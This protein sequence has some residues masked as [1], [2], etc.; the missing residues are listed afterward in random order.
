MDHWIWICVIVSQVLSSIFYLLSSACCHFSSFFFFSFHG[1]AVRGSRLLDKNRRLNLLNL[2]L[3]CSCKIRKSESICIQ[4]VPLFLFVSLLHLLT[5]ISASLLLYYVLS[6]FRLDYCAETMT[7]LQKI[8]ILIDS[9]V[10]QVIYDA[11]MLNTHWFQLHKC[12][13]LAFSLCMIDCFL[14]L[15]SF[16]M[17]D[18]LV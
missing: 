17:A 4:Y 15:Y 12:E 8:T 14:C 1:T 5:L 10:L 7:L 13:D 2:L 6:L 3:L 18:V 9:S 11:E 16:V